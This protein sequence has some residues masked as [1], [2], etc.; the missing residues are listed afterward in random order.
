MHVYHKRTTGMNGN[1]HKGGAPHYLGYRGKRE[2]MPVA[3]APGGRARATIY[4]ASAPLPEDV[5]EMMFSGFLRNEP[6]ELV[7]CK[8]IDIEVPAH[9]ETILEGYVDPDAQRI[10]G[11]FRAHPGYHSPAAPYPVFHVTCVTRRRDPI[12]TAPRGG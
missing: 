9:A 5:D 6:V 10:E 8:T 11:P 4:P 7:R 12:Y 2:R 1:M 3:G